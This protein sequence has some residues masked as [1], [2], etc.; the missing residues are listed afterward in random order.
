MRRRCPIL[1]S[2]IC[3]VV[4]HLA[5]LPGAPLHSTYNLGGPERLSRVDMAAAVADHFGYGRGCIEAIPGA[6]A[7]DRCE[8]PGVGGS[9]QWL[10]RAHA[11]TA[12]DRSSHH[13]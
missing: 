6:D 7:P 10:P 8:G 11:C 5:A 13:R 4:S 1:V 9:R 3:Q 12:L 2:D